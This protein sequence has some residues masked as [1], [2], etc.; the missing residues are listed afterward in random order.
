M[1]PLLSAV[2]LQ[3]RAKSADIGR[4]HV[5]FFKGRFRTLIG[6]VAI[7]AIPASGSVAVESVESVESGVEA[8]PVAG[9]LVHRF[10][11]EEIQKADWSHVFQQ[12]NGLP[13]KGRFFT[14]NVDEDERRRGDWSLRIHIFGGSVSYRTR[15]EVR[16]PAH[17]DSRFQLVGSV[18]TLDLRHASARFE[19]RLVDGDLLDRSHAAGMADAIEVATVASFVSEAVRTEGKWQQL[20]V[21]V[22]TSGDACR[23]VASDLR[24]VV[25][26]Q[27][28]Q[29]GSE[30]EPGMQRS[31]AGDPRIEDVTGTV[32]FDDLAV[33]Q[34]P[35]VDF[36]SISPSGIVRHP[37]PIELRIAVD[38][39]I[40]P[41]P[42]VTLEISDL[43]GNLVERRSIRSLSSGRPLIASVELPLPG[44]YHARLLVNG[45]GPERTVRDLAI[46]VLPDR[47]SSRLSGVPSLGYSIPEW[48]A[49]DLGDIATVIEQ[50]DPGAIEFSIWPEAND[51]LTSTDAIPSL[52]QVFERQRA[53]YR[54]PMLA[55]D[56]LHRG[57]AR[58]ARLQTT[59]V[60]AA[61]LGGDSISL[62]SLESWMDRFGTIV[63]RWRIPGGI[64]PGPD[65]KN[66]RE[67]MTSL[68]ADPVLAISQHPDSIDTQWGDELFVMGKP[69]LSSV[70]MANLFAPGVVSKATLRIEAPPSDWISKDRVDAA[71][72]RLLVA[73]R[74]G[75]DRLLF[76]WIPAA[77]PDPTMLAWTGL[78]DTLSGRRF[79]GEISVSPTA[80]CWIAGDTDESHLVI[81]SELQGSAELVRVPVGAQP[82]EVVDLEG[83]SRRF[84]PQAGMIELVVGSTPLVI[85]GVSAAAVEIAARLR[86]EPEAMDLAA[87]PQNVHLLIHNP[88]S[89][90][91]EGEASIKVPRGWSIEPARPR[92][93]IAA[94]E[95]ARVPIEIRWTI[96]PVAGE[97][98]L[99]VAVLLEADSAIRFDGE[100]PMEVRNETLEVRTDWALTTSAVDGSPGIVVSAEVINH[101]DRPMDLQME[102]VAW[103]SGRER[104]PISS[105]Q[106]GERA[107][108]RFH[109]KGGL[110]RLAQ[111]DVRVIITE[112]GGPLGV[113]SLIPIAGGARS[114]DMAL[115][116]E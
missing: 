14:A 42:T 96:P 64:R 2:S 8:P 112:L 89:V 11:F 90:A 55:I 3:S 48:K 93:R 17:I 50:L 61:M 109:F 105:L 71:A 111:T 35:W 100:I 28:T 39:P 10:D 107:V 101:G 15:P 66:L 81:W 99:P 83:R 13:P 91:M 80:R 21:D 23:A 98:R 34:L 69:D 40:E 53:G 114:V 9:R 115:V 87:G 33:W 72:R 16:L 1:I 54:E 58:A 4:M 86:F 88:T 26:M 103:H 29:P 68:V 94:G 31:V 57:L 6:T 47:V 56:R 30:L 102:A 63:D 7:L 78:N 76:P 70:T 82:V 77:G 75:A 18:R 84:D 59:E 116:E 74:S 32:W 27:V 43:D 38:D 79:K 37:A 60:Y 22:D 20:V 44:W 19:V 106:P 110:A 113:T 46:L 52:K 5:S 12:A 62:A 73:W 36:K 92:V 25:A 49:A 41:V 45:A 65:L 51:E 85:H 67:V 108:R 95:T 24:F 97:M 104:R